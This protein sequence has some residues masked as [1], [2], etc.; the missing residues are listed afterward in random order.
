MIYLGPVDLVAASFANQHGRQRA[1]SWMRTGVNCHWPSAAAMARNQYALGGRGHAFNLQSQL[2]KRK[3]R[4][5]ESG[6][7]YW[8][9]G[10]WGTSALHK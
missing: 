7:L 2:P 3:P 9:S 4:L 10:G 6:A 5:G 1:L 8:R